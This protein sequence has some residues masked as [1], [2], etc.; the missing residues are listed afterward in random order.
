M[1]SGS[2]RARPKRNAASQTRATIPTGSGQGRRAREEAEGKVIFVEIR[3]E[4]TIQH[5]DRNLTS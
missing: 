2:R 1:G 4:G 5:R 3:T